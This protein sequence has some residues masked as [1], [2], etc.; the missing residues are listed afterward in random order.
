MCSADVL[1][2]AQLP[3]SLHDWFDT[4]RLVKEVAVD[5]ETGDR[6]PMAA[7]LSLLTRRAS[8]KPDG[9]ITALFIQATL[10][11]LALPDSEHGG[12]RLHGRAC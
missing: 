8:L 5:A 11:F 10:P 2:R 9:T 6:S 12:V 1:V 7:R 3:Q 4:S